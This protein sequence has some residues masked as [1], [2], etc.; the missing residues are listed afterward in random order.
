[1]KVNLKDLLQKR[2]GHFANVY[3]SFFSGGGDQESL[4]VSFDLEEK[5]IPQKHL[6]EHWS[7]FFWAGRK[8]TSM[9]C[10]AM[11]KDSTVYEYSLFQQCREG[12]RNMVFENAKLDRSHC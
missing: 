1:M 2:L 12:F 7:G 6:I 10:A 9:E 4:N 3:T 5:V 11:P 8:L